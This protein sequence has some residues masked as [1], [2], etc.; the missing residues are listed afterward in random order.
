MRRLSEW[1]IKISSG[2]VTLAALLIFIGFTALVLPRQAS[3]GSSASEAV[4][5][6][7]LSLVYSSADLYRMAEAYGV[8]GRA[9]YI[10]VRFTFDLIWPVVYTVFLVSAMSWLYSHA[11]R[12]GSPWR[13]TNLVPL[14]AVTLDYLENI[15][16]SL[17]M[18][19]YPDSCVLAAGSAPFFTLLKWTM[20]AGSFGLLVFGLVAAIWRSIE[21]RRTMR[22]GNQS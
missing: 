19:R 7:D 3:S 14:L 21:G 2:W 22:H 11:F 20:V 10:R 12:P 9:E 5:S 15:S 6:P 4:G 16:T 18:Y 8:D 1:L 17:V 13:L